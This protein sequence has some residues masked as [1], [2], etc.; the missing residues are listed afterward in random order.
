MIDVYIYK[1]GEHYN[2]FYVTGHADYAER[3]KDIVCAAVSALTFTLYNSL[4][5]LSDVPV[6]EKQYVWQ[7]SPGISIPCPSDKT[8]VMIG[9]YKIGIEGVREAFPDYVTLHLET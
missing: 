1:N 9:Q 7:E 2:Q 3:G 5:E 4:Q 6:M 8:D